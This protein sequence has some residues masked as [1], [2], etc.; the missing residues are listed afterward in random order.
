MD[1]LD[2]ILNA[3]EGM[4]EGELIDLIQHI[5]ED[6]SDKKLLAV[7]DYINGEE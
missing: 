4:D 1:T 3:A 5:L 2:E 7:L 6:V